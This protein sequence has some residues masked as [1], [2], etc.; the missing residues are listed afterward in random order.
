MGGG[1]PN[2]EINGLT[3]DFPWYVKYTSL[4]FTDT[5]NNVENCY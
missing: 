1:M 2:M 3:A 5:K 4:V